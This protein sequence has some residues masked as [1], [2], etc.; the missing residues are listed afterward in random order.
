MNRKQNYEK[1][2]T[3]NKPR[4]TNHSTFIWLSIHISWASC[5]SNIWSRIAIKTSYIACKKWHGCKNYHRRFFQIYC[6]ILPDPEGRFPE[7][8]RV[9]DVVKHPCHFRPSVDKIP[10]KLSIAPLHG[11]GAQWC[12]FTRHL[13]HQTMVKVHLIYKLGASMTIGI[14]CQDNFFFS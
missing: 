5:L 13:Y 4:H 7:F 8:S 10:K 12:D 3:G 6:R 1:S 11:S 2:K 9:W 14:R